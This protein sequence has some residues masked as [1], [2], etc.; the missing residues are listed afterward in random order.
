MKIFIDDR[1]HQPDAVK[2]L[3]K[4]FADFQASDLSRIITR[5]ISYE[6]E[7]VSAALYLSVEKGLITYELKELLWSQIES[8]FNAHYRHIKSYSWEKNNAFL[9]Y[10]S[11]YSDDEIYDII[12]NPK[13]IMTDVFF[14]ILTVAKDRELISE[15][16]FK[17]YCIDAK[18]EI[19]SEHES[20]I[21][22]FNGLSSDE[23]PENLFENKEE[24]E[25]E[26]EKFWKCPKCNKLVGMEFGIC[27]NCEAE[28]SSVV[29]HPDNAEIIEDRKEAISE[30]RRMGNPIR[31]GFFIAVFGT[32]MALFEHY[33]TYYSSFAKQTRFLGV[34]FG[35][36]IALLG[37]IILGYGLYI[38]RRKND[39]LE[40]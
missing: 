4:K 18:S 22:E 9:K 3:V 29:E 20:G 33:R 30:S 36:F 16:D 39:F 7:A 32:I 28:A 25:A 12:D 5:Y 15:E 17:N 35:I 21:G 40:N 23:D 31:S 10:V 8:N 14:A 2:D 26:K 1:F 11:G 38:R 6:P 19:I 37:I 24:M 27:W 13:D 34:G